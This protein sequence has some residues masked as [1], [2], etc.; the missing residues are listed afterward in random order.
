MEIPSDLKKRK[1]SLNMLF[2]MNNI[3]MKTSEIA[4]LIYLSKSGID[5]NKRIIKERGLMPREEVRV[6]N[7]FDVMRQFP[8]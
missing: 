8:L 2:I 1:I 5:K 3:E 7:Y 4:K 6:I